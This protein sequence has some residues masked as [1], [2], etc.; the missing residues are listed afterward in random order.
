MSI[1]DRQLVHKTLIKIRQIFI[2]KCTFCIALILFTGLSVSAQE[3]STN[4]IYRFNLTECIDFA[5]QHQRSM[6][7]A[8]LD[9]QMAMEEVAENKAK[10]LPHAHINGSF[11]NNLKLA[12]TLM[13]DFSSGDLT[14]K[15]PVQ[16]GNR[17]TSS[18]TGQV[19][20]TILNSNYFIGLKAA[21]VFTDLSTKNL[22]ATEISTRVN[23]TKAFYSVLVNQEGLRISRSNL[24]QLE[25]SLKDVKAKYQAGVSE[26]VDVNRI[27]VQYNNAVTG[28]ENQQRIVD[29][30]L[31]QLKFQ[32]GL[33][34][35]DS[36][37]VTQTV[38]DISFDQTQRS[39]TSNFAVTDRPEYGMQQT[40]ILLN[41]LSLKSAKLS[42]LPS[43][44][45]YVNYGFNYFASSLGALYRKGYG[46]SALGLSLNFPLFSGTERLHQI[47]EAKITLERSQNDL[48]NLNQQI[49]LEVKQAYLQYENNAASLK[50][51]QENMSLTQGVYDRINYKFKQGVASSLDLLSAENELQT[52][53]SQYIDA[54]LNTLIS[55]VDLEAA[56][57]K[58]GRK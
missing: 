25:K 23:V 3:P 11:I 24:D 16:F 9:R 41:Q 51:Q 29:F 10:F 1:T 47:N 28:I 50:T 12:T 27:Q 57:G 19:D 55:K 35:S 7:N 26:T 34:Q 42:N 8:R 52:A 5:L 31:A 39:D 21:K 14:H 46:S 36:L 4:Q 20:Q 33:P 2:A 22:E 44:S 54:L 45:A 58:L 48:D 15:I 40:Q 56:M 43:L 30:S 37:V 17:Y 6:K 32:M 38:K 49:R 13:P 53:Q 18:L